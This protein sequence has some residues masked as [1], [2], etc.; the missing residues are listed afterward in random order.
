MNV[1]EIKSIL[2]GSAKKILITAHYKPDGDA[3]G[4]SLGLF[5]VL[6]SLGHYVTVM[7]PSYYPEF[8]QWIP[9]N[10]E[11]VIFTQH[12]PNGIGIINDAEIIFAL[13]YNEFSRTNGMSVYLRDA[14]AIK[15]MIDHHL[16]PEPFA[17]LTISEPKASSTCELVFDFICDIGQESLVSKNVADALFT[18]LLTDTGCFKY[19]TNPRVH[20]VASKLMQCGADPETINRYVFDCFSQDR[21]Q[22]IGYSLSERLE[23]LP[24]FHTAIIPL[25]TEDYQKFNFKIGDNEGLVNY[26]LM[27]KNVV[28]SILVSET[29]EIVKLSFRSKGGFAVNELAGKYFQGGGHKNASGGRSRKTLTQT[30]ERL[31]KLLPQYQEALI[32]EA[33]KLQPTLFPPPIINT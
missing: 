7:M 26:P 33:A 32:A 1:Q 2:T 6:K 5:H 12:I 9:G 21:L 15:I 17:D 10:E 28:M 22:L 3:I 27:L 11:V 4:S 23:V 30:V 8:L 16:N 29:D 18:G 25:S 31:K 19:N 14:K 24:E 13:D 20:E